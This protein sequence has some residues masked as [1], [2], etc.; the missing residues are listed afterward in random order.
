MLTTICKWG[1]SQ[2]IRLP[3]LILDMLNLSIDDELDIEVDQDKIV[4]KKAIKNEI[5]IVKLFENF[6]DSDY[7]P[8]KVDWGKPEGN[9]IW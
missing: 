5:D 3:K 4:I 8:N 2:G 1:N 9:E 6:N 7:V